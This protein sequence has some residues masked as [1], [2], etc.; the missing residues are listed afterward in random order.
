MLLTIGE[1]ALGIIV[2]Y[3]TYV[4]AGERDPLAGV[5]GLAVGL[6][7]SLLAATLSQNFE[8]AD[9][10]RRSEERLNHLIAGVSDR[11]ISTADAASVLRFGGV[12]IP[13]AEVTRVWLDRVWRTASRYWGVI[14]TAPDEVV[15]TNIF[16][17]G[18]A[19]L[20]AKVRVD[21]VDVRRI[22]VVDDQNELDHMLPTMHALQESQ[23]KVR[24]ALRS[25]LESN[26]LI[27]AQIAELS[28]LDFTVMDSFVVWNLLLDRARR[29]RA[30]S[31]HFDE[32]LNA[33]YA[34]VFRLLWDA[35][36]NVTPILQHGTATAGLT[37]A[38]S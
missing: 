27:R 21:Q 25:S 1:L 29:I 23:M 37:K 19:V 16:Q 18:V 15:D 38:S 17:L 3:I 31:L 28:T 13:R 22:F 20:S 12:E 34:E 35:A 5:L 7:T 33:K 10:F 6:L 8:Q 26:P 30:G 11:L 2:G 36:T 32:R 24:Y 4:V 14:Y 9:Q